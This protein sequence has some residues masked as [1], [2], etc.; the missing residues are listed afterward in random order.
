MGSNWVWT[1]VFHQL[2]TPAGDVVDAAGVQGMLSRF[3]SGVVVV[4]VVHVRSLH[5]RCDK[6]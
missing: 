6:T 4:L 2:A 1:V 5:V 3:E